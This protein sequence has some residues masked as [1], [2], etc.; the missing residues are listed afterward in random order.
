MVML[1]QCWPPTRAVQNPDDDSSS[2]VGSRHHPI[3]FLGLLHKSHQELD[4]REGI[5][6]PKYRPW[7]FRKT[8]WG[9][10]KIWRRRQQK[11][12]ALLR[13]R[14]WWFGQ[15]FQELWN[16]PSPPH[17]NIAK[18]FCPRCAGKPTN[19]DLALHTPHCSADEYWPSLQTD[20]GCGVCFYSRWLIKTTPSKNDGNL[21]TLRVVSGTNQHFIGRSSHLDANSTGK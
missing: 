8:K 20:A 3:V 2:Q 9:Y 6:G 15:G 5:Q 16:C 19:E 11:Q 4:H 12:W 10:L 7:G 21:E 13:T 18:N 1:L 14:H 17:T